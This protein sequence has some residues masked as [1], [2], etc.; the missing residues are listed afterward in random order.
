MPHTANTI[1]ARDICS[2]WRRAGFLD[3]FRMLI[4]IFLLITLRGLD[5]HAWA[6]GARR[7]LVSAYAYD[8]I[9]SLSYRGFIIHR[10][11]RMTCHVGAHWP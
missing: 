8:A 5:T 7:L 10:F 3:Y 2:L 9:I 11:T 6:I 4:S 1:G